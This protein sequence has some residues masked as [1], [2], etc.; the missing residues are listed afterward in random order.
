MT[1]KQFLPI[2]IGISVLATILVVGD[3]LIGSCGGNLKTFITFQ[4]WAMYFMAGCTV[5]GAVR[6]M[7][8][9]LGGALASIAIMELAGAF[10]GIPAPW[11]LGLAVFIIVIPVICA[12]R[13]P[14]FNFVPAWF[15]GAG[16]YFAIMSLGGATSHGAATTQLMFSCF[17]GMI[18]G[19][20]TVFGRG[21]YEASLAAKQPAGAE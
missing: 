6:V 15:V 20:V 12:E 13:V 3:A 5:M 19:Y 21:K 11:G 9:Y 1:F 10:S 4:A 16:M 18:F 17:I 2:P 8:G 7:C 14:A